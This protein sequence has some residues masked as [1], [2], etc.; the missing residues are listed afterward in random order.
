MPPAEAQRIGAYRL[1]ERLGE[2]GMAVVYRARL[3]GAGGFARDVVIKRLR[4][5]LERDAAVAE[6]LAQEARLCSRLAHPGIVRVLDFARAGAERFL[7]MEYVDGVDLAALARRAGA[8]GRPLPES[9]V[10]FALVEAARALAY[11]HALAD[12]DGRRLAIIHREVSPSNLMLTSAGHVKLLDFGVAR[13]AGQ[14]QDARTRTGIFRGKL[15]YLSPE[16]AEGVPIDRRADLFALGVVAH[17]CLTGRGVFRGAD[18]L[19]TLRLVRQADVAPPSATRAGVDRELEGVVMRLLAPSPDARF[20]DG[21]AVADAVRPIMHRLGG[22]AAAARRLLAAL[23]PI[24]TGR[25][26]LAAPG[27]RRV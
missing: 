15:G 18:D 2:G 21:D 14:V 5:E 19:E 26:P 11:A 4:P 13:A 9:V 17:E 8:L 27:P 16:Q 23:A 25:A 6:M 7:V 22:D 3:D 1:L 24:E 20:A 12:G 10:S